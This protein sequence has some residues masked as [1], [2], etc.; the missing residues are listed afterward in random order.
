MDFNQFDSV[1]ASNRGAWMHVK[2][3]VTGD[4]LYDDGDE[5]KPC[6]VLVY[7]IEGDA[8][9]KLMEKERAAL[10]EG[11][12]EITHEKMVAETSALIGGFENIN[13]GDKPATAPDDVKWFLDLQRV[14]KRNDLTFASQ[15]RDFALDR[16]NQLGNVSGG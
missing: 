16:A 3:P 14:V 9:Q 12:A 1:A 15:V 10:K 7:G 6:R 4:P 2:S 8:G 13:R 11:K 5:S